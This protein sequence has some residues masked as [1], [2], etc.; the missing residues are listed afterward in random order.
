MGCGNIT[1]QEAQPEPEG[2]LDRLKKSVEALE[3]PEALKPE[4][5]PEA[6]RP[7]DP[8]PIQLTIEGPDTAA[9]G[10]SIILVVKGLPPLDPNAKVTEA[11]SWAYSGTLNT[12]VSAPSEGT[13]TITPYIEMPVPPTKYDYNLKFVGNQLG[14]Y[15]VI[16]AWQSNPVEIVY[17]RITVGGDPGPNPT[18]TTIKISPQNTTTQIGGTIPYTATGMDQFGSPFSLT[19]STWSVSEGGGMIE[20]VDDTRAT[21]SATASSGEFTITCTSGSAIGSTKVI[22][23]DGPPASDIATLV[24]NLAEGLVTGSTK[25]S[26][27]EKLAVN[28]DEIAKRHN[29][30]KEAVPPAGVEPIA[31]AEAGVSELVKLNRA[32]LG[33]RASAWEQFSIKYGEELGKL[34]ADGKIEKTIYGR[35]KAYEESAKGLRLAWPNE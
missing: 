23:T 35:A 22:V 16:L 27:A 19:G 3:K 28:Y 32:A 8:D 2:A 21:Y 6:I 20:K 10:E 18:L 9:I 4:A 29:A 14:I 15:V 31:T 24:K 33:S 1:A 30:S 34:E 11:F 25:K 26:E 17:H 13:Y 7:S 5:K 12:D